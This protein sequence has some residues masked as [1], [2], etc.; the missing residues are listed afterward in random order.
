MKFSSKKLYILVPIILTFALFYSIKVIDQAPLV[1]IHTISDNALLDIRYA[2]TNNFTHQVIYTQAECYIHKDLVEPL[3]KVIANLA[4]QN[5]RL[6]FYDCYRPVAAQFK[7]WEIVPDDRYVANPYT[8]GSNHNRGIAL[9]ITLVDAQG[10]ELAM[11][12]PYDTF[13]EAAH[14]TYM[15]LPEP[16]LA[17]RTL[18]HN[19][20]QAEGFKPHAFE[21]WH[22]DLG[23]PKDYL[24]I[25]TTFEKLE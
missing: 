20:M 14:T 10:Q 11:P 9:D 15:N 2:S 17:N 13:S 1:N 24:L 25:D 4:K 6:K 3:Q 8:T 18:F 12:T 7:L 19:I 23:D 16:I 21:W 22:F 5:L